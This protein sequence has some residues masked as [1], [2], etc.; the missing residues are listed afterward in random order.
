MFGSC[1]E[2]ATTTVMVV[3]ELREGGMQSR[4]TEN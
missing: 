1:M 2:G 4:E 3:L